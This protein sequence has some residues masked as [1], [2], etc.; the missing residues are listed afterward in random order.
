MLFDYHVHCNLSADCEEPIAAYLLRAAELGVDEFCFTDH[1]EYDYPDENI[2]FSNPPLN[3][4]LA[5]YTAAFA[6]DGPFKYGVEAGMCMDGDHNERMQNALQGETALDFILASTH[7][8]D[9]IDPYFPAF[10]E[11]RTRQQCF[12]RYLRDVYG[13]IRRM[14]HFSVVGHIDYPTK[15]CPLEDKLL[16]YEDAPDVFDAIFRLIICRGQGLELNTSLYEKLGGARCDGAWLK[17]YR[18][19]GG[20]I[21]TIGSDAHSAK[22]LCEG[23]ANALEFIRAA[24]LRYICT[25]DKLKPIFHPI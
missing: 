16:R 11:R 17:R 18:E 13:N 23:F 1:F 14:A 20:E 24:G 8:V 21:I 7:V 9:G 15:G 2:D 25:F 3:K 10:F 12:E 4:R 5:L 6:A 22:R 19:L